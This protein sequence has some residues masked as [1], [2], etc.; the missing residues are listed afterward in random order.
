MKQTL[1]RSNARMEVWC[2]PIWCGGVSHMGATLCY[3]DAGVAKS[4]AER[5]T[6]IE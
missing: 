5:C 6:A 2:Q 1:L 4:P 3:C